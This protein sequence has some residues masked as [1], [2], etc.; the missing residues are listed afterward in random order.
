MA[1]T[2]IKPRLTQKTLDALGMLAGYIEVANFAEEEVGENS[3][4]PVE[5]KRASDWIRAMQ[6]WKP[7]KKKFKE[8]EYKR[9]RARIM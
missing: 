3:D 4:I 9:R 8:D 2:P 6:A 5:M 1:D 7:A